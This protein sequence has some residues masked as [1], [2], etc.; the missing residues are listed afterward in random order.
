MRNIFISVMFIYLLAGCSYKSK[1]EQKQVVNFVP[2]TEQTMALLSD[3][4]YDLDDDYKL[5]LREIAELE[6][7]PSIV[8]MYQLQK[9]LM[10]IMRG[11]MIYSLQLGSI[12]SMDANGSVKSNYLADMIIRFN[13]DKENEGVIKGLNIKKEKFEELITSMRQSQD[14]LIAMQNAQIVINEIMRISM[15]KLDRLRELEDDAAY[16]VAMKIDEKFK[17]SLTFDVEV[18]ERRQKNMKALRFLV[19]YEEGRE[20]LSSIQTLDIFTLRDTLKNKKHLSEKELNRAFEIIHKNLEELRLVKN[21]VKPDIQEYHAYL[22]E[23]HNLTKRS[24]N[25]IKKT[26][27]SIIL[28]ARAHA[29]M[30]N[31]KWLPSEWFGFS[32]AGSLLMKAVKK[33]SPI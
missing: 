13:H 28:W 11:I 14:L 8:E 25:S 15:Q 20:E 17:E 31:G 23:F 10:T 7:D 12:A 5:Y 33:A 2:F 32:D 30:S 4:D 27:R 21:D 16:T 22:N 1:F 24:N 19:A 3:V 18:H 6:S 26:R 9:E 29:A